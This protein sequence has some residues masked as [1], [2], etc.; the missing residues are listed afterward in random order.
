MS[1]ASSEV[2]AYL[3][4]SQNFQL[5]LGENL[6]VGVGNNSETLE[7]TCSVNEEATDKRSPSEIASLL[8]NDLVILGATSINKFS[9]CYGIIMNCW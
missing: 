3:A 1:T 2:L 4:S 5:E 9:Y 6:R 8:T 7:E